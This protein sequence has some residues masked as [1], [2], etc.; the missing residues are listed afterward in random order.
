MKRMGYA[1]CLGLLLFFR[2]VL[3]LAA[4]GAPE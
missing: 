2:L 4:H 1:G 3:P